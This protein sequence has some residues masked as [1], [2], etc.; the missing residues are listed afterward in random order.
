LWREGLSVFRVQLVKRID[1]LPLTCDYM[2]ESERTMCF[3]GHEHVP[4]ANRAA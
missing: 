4:R 2:F 1:A 3:A